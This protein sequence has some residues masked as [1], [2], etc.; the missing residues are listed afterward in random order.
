LKV[1]SSKWFITFFFFLLPFHL[2]I[3]DIN[4]ERKHNF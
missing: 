2:N 4:M 1:Q 3:F